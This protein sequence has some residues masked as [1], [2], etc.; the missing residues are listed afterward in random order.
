MKPTVVCWAV[1]SAVDSDELGEFSQ[2]HWLLQL[3]NRF[4]KLQRPS[5]DV[6]PGVGHLPEHVPEVV[7]DHSG[8][9]GKLSC[10]V[11]LGVLTS[12]EPTDAVP[13]A[14]FEVGSE[15]AADHSE[16]RIAG[17]AFVVVCHS[18]QRDA[19]KLSAIEPSS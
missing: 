9:L 11:L 14:L 10:R 17:V 3:Q 4:E 19:A 6:M 7:V 18:L 1:P 2:T 8:L 13:A 12:P 5:P 16:Y 15:S